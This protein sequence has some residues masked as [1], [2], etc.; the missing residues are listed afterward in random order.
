VNRDKVWLRSKGPI[1][2]LAFIG[3]AAVLAAVVAATPARAGKERNGEVAREH[4]QRAIIAYN[5]GHFD[6]AADCG[7]KA[8]LRPN[9]HV[10]VLAIG[11]HCLAL[12]GR[13]DEARKLTGSILR[14]VPGYRVD[15]FLT[16]FRFT[17]DAALLVRRGAK[18]IGLG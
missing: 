9:A 12:A 4:A 5:L 3:L 6:E 14:Q 7:A 10:H 18:L 8:A 1:A 16:A 17:G 15:D 13:V 11:A 2:T